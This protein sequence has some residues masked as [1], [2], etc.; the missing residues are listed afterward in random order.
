MQRFADDRYGAVVF[1]VELREVLGHP[2]LRVDREV[3][4][5]VVLLGKIRHLGRIGLRGGGIF[6]PLTLAVFKPNC[7]SSKWVI[8]SMVAS[9]AVAIIA[10]IMQ[11]PVKPMFLAVAVSLLLLLPG[12][13]GKKE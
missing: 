8:I 13:A 12:I 11:T 9:T 10:T 7:V 1:H 2:A 3:G 5:V 6:L 4:A